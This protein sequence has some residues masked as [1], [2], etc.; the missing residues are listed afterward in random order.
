MPNKSQVKSQASILAYCFRELSPSWWGKH[1]IRAQGGHSQ[2]SGMASAFPLLFSLG[3][4]PWSAMSIIQGGPCTSV[5]DLIDLS[6]AVSPRQLQIKLG[7]QEPLTS[8]SCIHGR[9]TVFSR[10]LQNHHPEQGTVGSHSKVG[11]E[12]RGKIRP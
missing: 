2:Q 4:E 9:D 6:G 5:N 12:V 8:T 1:G 7:G 10:V 3:T 11:S